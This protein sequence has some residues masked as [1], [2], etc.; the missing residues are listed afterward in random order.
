M[1][2]LLRRGR[3]LARR[4]V[5]RPA[6]P[7]RLHAGK[8]RA[9]DHAFG[10]LGARSFADLGAVWAVNGGYTFHALRHH[11]VDRAVL[12]D[13]D[14]TPEVRAHAERHPQLS[15]IAGNFGAPDMPERIGDVDAVILFDVL[16]HQV[17]P[18]WDEI[19]AMYAGRA[20]I[21]IVSNPQLTSV[22]ETVRLIEL[23]P[24]RYRE[25][26]PPG[27]YPPDLFE[28]LDEEV[29]GRGRSWRDVHEVWQWGIT[30]ADLTAAAAKLGFQVAHSE[31]LGRWRGLPEF[32]DHTFVLTAGSPRR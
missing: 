5:G 16:L 17:S 8:V 14:L 18:D 21:L 28:R 7:F 23:G 31:N 26:V 11:E 15:L 24:E 19:L 30:D 13:E 12:V 1:T 6:E 29:P 2:G 27:T 22:D 4:A 9:L 20:R 25:L 32:E 10:R 3:G